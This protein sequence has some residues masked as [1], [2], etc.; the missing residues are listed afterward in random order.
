[1]PHESYAA[2]L[3]A[4][5]LRISAISAFIACGFAMMFG[6]VQSAKRL[7]LLAI[8][9]AFGAAFAPAFMG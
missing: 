3:G 8:I 5:L 4:F 6:R 9:L 7:G 2:A 1:M